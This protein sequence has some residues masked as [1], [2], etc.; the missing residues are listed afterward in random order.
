M[1][2]PVSERL[3]DVVPPH[4]SLVESMRRHYGG[5]EAV[6]VRIVLETCVTVRK[7]G[8]APDRRVIQQRR[9]IGSSIP[10]RGCAS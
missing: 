1:N 8:K 3:N 5:S 10:S 4:G 6:R 2:E 9:G 7:R